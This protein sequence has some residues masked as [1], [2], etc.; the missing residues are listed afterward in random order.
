M[1]P[2]KKI[3]DFT[4]EETKQLM[5]LSECAMFSALQGPDITLLFGNKKL[6]SMIQYTP[7]EFSEKF[8]NHL[9]EIILP[10]DKQK[11]RMLIARQSTMG[12]VIHLEFRIRRKDG[13]AQWISLSASSIMVDDTM[14]Y[15]CS[16]IN[17]TQQKR[18]LQEVYN[19]KQEVD[20]IANSI[21]G[22]VI[23]LRVFD[24]TLLYANDGFYQ[25]SGYSRADYFALFGNQCDK[26]I[27]PD[28]VKL[29]KS[30]VQS[31]VENHGTLSFAYRILDKNKDVRWFYINGRRVEDQ[32]CS[33]VYLCI[34]MDITDRKRMEEKLED[35]VRRSRYLHRYMKEVEWTYHVDIDK[36]CRSGDLI[37]TF[38]TEEEVTDFLAGDFIDKITHPEDA[39]KLR[40]AIEERAR[41]IGKS[42]SV[43]RV[44]NNQ[45]NFH[46]T[47]I[48]M[49]SI[50]LTDD[51]KPDRI[52]G[53]SRMLQENTVF[54]SSVA[55]QKAS[56]QTAQS[57]MIALPEGDSPKEERDAV[58]DLMSV[59]EFV[60]AVKEVLASRDEKE[61][62]GILCCDI[63]AFQ[64]LNF[65]Y[66]VSSG[67]E[68]LRLYGGVLSRSLAYNN[69][70][71]RVK[72][73]YFMLLF[74][75]KEYRELLKTLSQM[76]REMTDEE[77][78]VSYKIFGLTCGIYLVQSE[79]KDS[80][81]NH[82]IECADLARRSIKGI[83]GNH[84]SIY[85]DDLERNRFYEEELI[86][87]IS[88]AMQNGAME[89]CYQ[90]RIKETKENV[91]GCKVVP[92]VQRKN[93][94]YIPL[95]DIRRYVDRNSEIQQLPFYVLSHVCSTM[96]AWK[97]KGKKIM[98][99]SLDITQGQLCMQGAVERIDQMVKKNNIDPYSIIFE[100]Q[101]QNF[102]ELIPDFQ[103]ALE[104]LHK[105]G[106]RLIISRFGSDHTA[107]Y[108]VHHLPIY[109]I[110]FH[111]EFFRDNMAND[112]ERKMF[113]TSV[114]LVK[115]L[116]LEVSCGGIH[117]KMQEDVAR[118]IGCDI[119][120]G[121]MYYGSIRND[122]YE[123]CFL[124]N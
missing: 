105:R 26:V 10:E 65:H 35:N 124:S 49:V 73:D 44:K 38:S 18:T 2:R 69:L 29:V 97:A 6:Y 70:A 16:C 93:G 89:I 68:I 24:F 113:S 92:G 4:L 28:D 121:D 36:F 110:K 61:N 107:L 72:G 14:R 81:F 108:S 111:G 62:Y 37:S 53:E 57:E 40:R 1:K 79:D 59:K 63:N 32:D 99:V 20:T 43:F 80:D 122:V 30:M 87:E 46:S 23:K 103:L 11:V 34:I 3:K 17:I 52:Y 27:Y 82:M 25:I 54:A 31:A 84:F 12:G 83:R 33:P 41:T 74:Q 101:E 15:Y 45:G 58:T 88:E 114:K 90:P 13:V 56:V 96:G 8:Q 78:K 117:T 109:A 71:C 94:E 5:D 123:R 77:Q 102:K 51:D 76:M 85:T 39:D 112:K 7:E 55:A 116:G 100:I 118:E 115:E 9:M 66:G 22:G 98:P 120:E 67:N 64:K 119:L 21:P 47:L 75:Y 86:Q 91:I 42:Q 60:K 104:D 95:E 19:A 48:S 50:S 106:Y